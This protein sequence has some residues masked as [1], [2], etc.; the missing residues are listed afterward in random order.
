MVRLRHRPGEGNTPPH[1]GPGP[2]AALWREKT[3]MVP[4]RAAFILV[5]ALLSGAVTGRL[6]FL[7]S[8]GAAG[9]ALAG[10]ALVGGAVALLDGLSA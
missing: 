10:S 6:T 3:S 2:A 8:A 1:Y 4:L 5:A 9:S 7:S